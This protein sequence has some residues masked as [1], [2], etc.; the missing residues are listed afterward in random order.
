MHSSVRISVVSYLNSSPFIYGLQR[1]LGKFP[2]NVQLD[3]PSICAEK[4]I[5]GQ[6]DVGLIPVAVLK[7][8]PGYHIISDYCIG[9]KG[10]V[11]SVLL[12]SEVP[13]E[14]IKTILLD[15]Q[16]R[17]SVMLTRILA[18]ELWNINPE[19]ENTSA[20]YETSI[21][22]SKAGVVI[23]DRALQLRGKFPF[24]Y[25]LSEEWMK[26]TNLPFVFAVWVSRN[27]LPA[28]FISEFNSSLQQ[29]FDNM[30]EVISGLDK[31]SL[32][33]PVIEQYLLHHID[34]KLDDEKIKAM[35]LF[36]DYIK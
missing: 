33:K 18:T 30:A 8:I 6:A 5:S 21:H 9:A 26:M 25:D 10:P 13:L 27:K 7:Q 3:I 29:G 31:V 17:T 20:D 36:L 22:G 24:E 1:W 15:Y 19:W 11:T 35:N 4:L 14:K 34:Y 23:G 12:L 32:K 2:V 16:S 28:E